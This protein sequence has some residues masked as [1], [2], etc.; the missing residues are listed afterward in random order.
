MGVII[1]ADSSDRPTA[2]PIVSLPT[3][4]SSIMCT[5]QCKLHKG[6]RSG[7]SVDMIQCSVC[8]EWFHTECV[9]LKKDATVGIW[10]CPSCRQIPTQIRSIV[11]MIDKLTKTVNAIAVTNEQLTTALANKEAECNTLVNDN[12]T[13]STKVAT[14]TKKLSKRSWEFYTAK[15]TLLIGDSIIRNVDEN[16]LDNTIMRS[17]SGATIGDVHDELYIDDKLY[18]K[19]FVCAGTNDCSKSDMDIEVVTENFSTLLQVAQ[20]NVAAPNDVVV[21]SI[22]PRTD[23]TRTQQRVEELNSILQETSTTLGAKF[24]SNDTSFRLAGGLPSDG[25]LSADGLH[26]N[27]RGTHRL[28]TNLGLTPAGQEVQSTKTRTTR[29]HGDRRSTRQNERSQCRQTD[30]EWHTVRRYHDRRD[31]TPTNAALHS[32]ST[33]CCYF[34]G[35]SGHVKQNCRHGRKLQCHTCQSFGHKSKF[36]Q[37]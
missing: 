26:L 13:L 15:Q 12:K 8:A 35:E 19:I 30:N 22:P 24:I 25:Y 16:K 11:S 37:Y 4:G 3:T 34:C 31:S 9:G 36:C 2:P 20:A 23:S 33:P 7:R 29:N 17:M 28:A 10:P 5:E 18:K 21:S 6:K 32:G 1:D 14:I 27:Y